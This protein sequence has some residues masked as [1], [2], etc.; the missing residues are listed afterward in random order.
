MDPTWTP[1]GA[2]CIKNKSKID[3][4]SK[5]PLHGP[6]MDP[7]ASEMDPKLM[8]NPHEATWNQQIWNQPNKHPRAMEP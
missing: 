8:P 5:W 2:K 1:N 4:K 7:N 3:I 6:H